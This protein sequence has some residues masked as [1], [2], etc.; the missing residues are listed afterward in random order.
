MPV[1]PSSA[2]ERLGGPALVLESGATTFVPP[3][4]LAALDAA[5]HMHL[6]PEPGR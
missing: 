4:W 6:T 3:G 2:A 1:D 5:G